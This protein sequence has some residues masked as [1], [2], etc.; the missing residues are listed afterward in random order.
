MNRA[1]PADKSKPSEPA[2]TWLRRAHELL[3]RYRVRISVVVF[4][5]LIL[6]DMLERCRPRDLADVH[7]P[8][9]VAGLTLV[10]A[11]LALRSW[12]AGTLR[13]MAQ[14]TTEGPY[15]AMRNPLYVGSFM[16]MVGFSDLI[17]DEE[18]IYVVCG[19]I[20]LL[21]ILKVLSEERQLARKFGAA[22]NEYAARAPRFFPRRWPR[23][24]FDAWS[25]KQW[26]GSREYRALAGGL[27]GLVALELWRL[28]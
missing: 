2:P 1:A 19:P 18:N 22:W 10:I 28:A 24:A 4:A 11:G 17:N 25:F 3:M 6:E 13:K 8:W 27:L 12:A 23:R 5:A 26:L 20:L 21:Y 16:I 14:L 9:M 15:A 7:D